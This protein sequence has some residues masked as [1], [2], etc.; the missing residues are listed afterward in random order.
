MQLDDTAHIL[1]NAEFFS[2]CS[3]EQRRMLAF[4]SEW[5]R[6]KEGEILFK[7]GQIAPGAYVLISGELISTQKDIPSGKPIIITDPGAVIAELALIV[8]HPRRADV[9]CK[10]DAQLLMVPRSAF[11]KIMQQFPEI[12]IKAE[13]MVR[14]DISKYISNIEGAAKLSNAKK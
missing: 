7:A 11:S 13:A 10:T 4:A 2:I 3:L 1:G 12:A 5:V 6:F 9:V 8:K 14:S